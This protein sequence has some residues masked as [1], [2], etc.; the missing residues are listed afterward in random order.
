MALK[1]RLSRSGRKK[2]PHFGI[3]VMESWRKRDGKCIE[4]IGHYHPLLSEDNPARLVLDLD[5]A[6]H[7]FSVGA[8]PTEVV[9]KFMKKLGME[10][11]SSM[12]PGAPK[13]EYIGMSKKEVAEKIKS[14]EKERQDKKKA[15]D[16][17]KQN[18]ENQ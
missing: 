17:A 11:D 2:N 3:V 15:K 18:S 12:L 14:D 4:K 6:K 16:A 7:W 10:I 8:K 9:A 1:I 13:K 5:R